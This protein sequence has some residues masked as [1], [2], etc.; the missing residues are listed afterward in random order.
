[1]AE[2]F[3]IAVIGSGP[4]G[5]IAALKAAQMGAK[6][7]VIE[8]HLL[9]GAC[10]NYG[11]IPSKALLASAELL[12][13]IRTADSLGVEING[14]VSFNWSAIQK[15]KDKVLAKLRGGIKGLFTARQVKLFEGSASLEGPGRIAVADAQGRVSHIAADRII[16]ATGSSPARIPGWPEDPNLI[17]TSDEALH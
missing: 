13:K 1:M 11:C 2:H 6:T 7:A 15:R 14:S 17:C 5:Y 10:L 12:A 4:G 3:Q 8:R 16:L 9:G